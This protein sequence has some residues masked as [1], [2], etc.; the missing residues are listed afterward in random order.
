VADRKT[1]GR[2]IDAAAACQLA[3]TDELGEDVMRRITEHVQARPE[4]E[5][6]DPRRVLDQHRQRIQTWLEQDKPLKLVRVRELLARDGIDVS[7]TTLRR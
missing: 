2:Y 3:R 4:P 7:Y 5:R 1:A 6:S